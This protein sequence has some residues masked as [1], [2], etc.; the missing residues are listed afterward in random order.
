MRG[1]RLFVIV[2][3]GAL[4]VAA[5]AIALRQIVL[6]D[7][8][9]PGSRGSTRVA[10]IRMWEPGGLDIRDEKGGGPFVE[11]LLKADSTHKLET[12]IV[13]LFPRRPPMGGFEP[14]S[15]ED[16]DRLSARL[17]SGD[18]ISCCGLLGSPGPRFYDVVPQY[19]DTRFV[20]LDYCCA[21]GVELGALPMPL[22]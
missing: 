19:P 7:A 18:S 8:G 1:R 21:K 20:F 2:L 6:T 15:Q 11:G 16:V 10:L 22:R 4:A 5:T 14:G 12:E 3:A 17:R 9:L 13:D